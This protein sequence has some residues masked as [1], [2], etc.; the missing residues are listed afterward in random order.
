MTNID[1]A[2]IGRFRQKTVKPARA[3]LKT[4]LTN[5]GA[6]NQAAEVAFSPFRTLRCFQ[7]TCNVY[8]MVMIS[9]KSPRQQKGNELIPSCHYCIIINMLCIRNLSPCSSDFFF[10][11]A[12]NGRCIHV[13]IIQTYELLLTSFSTE[14]RVICSPISANLGLVS[15]TEIFC[16]GT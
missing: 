2:A 12:V 6:A 9:N 4:D 1:T 11:F 5:S 14:G 8:L 7:L 3:D 10:N 13:I 16:A 15:I